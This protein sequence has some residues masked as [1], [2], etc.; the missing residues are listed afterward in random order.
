LINWII[1]GTRR[2]IVDRGFRAF[3]R[4]TPRM[5]EHSPERMRV[6]ASAR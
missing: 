1:D 4:S 2:G 6:C 5:H 3:A